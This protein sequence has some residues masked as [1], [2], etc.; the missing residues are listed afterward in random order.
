VFKD[1]LVFPVALMLIGLGVVWLGVLWQRHEVAI[2]S[3]LQRWLPAR[4]RGMA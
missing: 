2:T 4:L 3:A 1:S